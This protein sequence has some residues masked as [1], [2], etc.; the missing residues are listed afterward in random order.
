M[1]YQ[2]IVGFTSC[3]DSAGE[4]LPHASTILI[5]LTG[6]RNAILQC[7]GSDVLSIKIIIYVKGRLTHNNVVHVM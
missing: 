1:Y 7:N 4:I 3:F 5:I 6:C 2:L